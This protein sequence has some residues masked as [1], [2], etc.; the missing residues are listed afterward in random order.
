[1]KDYSKDLFK[2]VGYSN[3]DMEAMVRPNI[4]YWAD[5]WRRLKKNKVAIASMIILIIIIFLCLVGPYLTPFKFTDQNYDILDKAPFG[6]HWF[7][8]DNLGRDLFAR[9]W[10]G[11]RVSL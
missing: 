3:A 8:T 4:S 9:L 6:K 1:M 7:G 2:I 11:G 10:K 5:A